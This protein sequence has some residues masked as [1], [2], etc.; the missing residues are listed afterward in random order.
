MTGRETVIYAYRNM[1]HKPQ[2]TILL[3]TWHLP[4]SFPKFYVLGW[5]L[6]RLDHSQHNVATPFKTDKV[7]GRP[8]IYGDL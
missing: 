7:E 4:G 6:E 3:W 5:S 2:E 1:T 8:Q